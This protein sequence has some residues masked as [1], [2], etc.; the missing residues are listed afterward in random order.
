MNK[1]GVEVQLYQDKRI[2]LTVEFSCLDNE[3][4]ALIG[5]S[6]SGKTTILRSIAGLYQ[7]QKGLIACQQEIWFDSVNNVCVAAHQRAAGF[8]FQNYALFPHLTALENIAVGLTYLPKSQKI[9]VAKKL[10]A[11]VHLQGL[12][13][14]YPSQLSGGQ[15]QRVAVARALAR[16]PKVLLLDEPFSAVDQVTRKRLYREM[17][18]LRHTLSIPIILVTHDLNEAHLLADK[19][20][21]LHKGISLQTGTPTEVATKPISTTVARLMDQQNIF[22]AEVLA[23][24]L[25]KN[26]TQLN[27][28]KHILTVPYQ[29]KYALK[30]QVNWM[31]PP[32]NILLH[33]KDR[34]SNGERENPLSG[35]IIESMLL[36]GYMNLVIQI[37]EN[38]KTNLHMSVPLHVA[39]RNQLQCGDIISVSLLTEGIHIFTH[40]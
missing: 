29:N 12:E 15:Q 22:T 40:T 16:Q 26:I 1:I 13:T 8:V 19:V 20:C 11:Q 23:H 31:I 35:L 25:E 3:V 37:N 38:L 6:G 7:A 14:R 2:P 27:W 33:R 17:F 39:K 32:A 36:G 4:L 34:V 10:L 18:E 30:Q 9:S 28:Q 5:P 24:N 21:L